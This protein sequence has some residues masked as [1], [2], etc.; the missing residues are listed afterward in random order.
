MATTPPALPALPAPAALPLL[1]L[2]LFAA[3]RL[4]PA[5]ALAST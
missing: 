3:A 1:A 2:P 4:P 5:A